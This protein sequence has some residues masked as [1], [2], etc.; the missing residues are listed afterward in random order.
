MKDLTILIT[1]CTAFSDMWSNTLSCFKKNWDDDS[2]IVLSSDG[3][4]IFDVKRVPEL[5]LYNGEMSKRIIDALK[6]IKT[7]Y[8]FITFDDY[9][10]I[11]KADVCTFKE[12]I[13]Y[14]DK[15]NVS[16]C[17]TAFNIK[18]GVKTH[19]GNLKLMELDLNKPYEVNFYPSI[20]NRNDLIDVLKYD[21]N[22]WVSEVRLTKR[23]KNN[24]K[25]A[26]L[27]LN[28]NVFPFLDVVRKGKY[29]RKAYKYLNKNDFY[30]SKR[31]VRT[32]REELYLSIRSFISFHSPKF[33]KKFLQN[34]YRKSGHI[35]FSDYDNLDA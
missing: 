19:S 4:G 6:D 35:I 22:I 2:G 3:E 14:M 9:Y 31:D 10:L 5:A 15:N 13:S 29:L 16:Y 25:K 32:R 17:G 21:E 11:E 12:L 20:W 33:L 27:I 24:G 7:K 34:K 28:K 1:S 8:V 26:I 18:S 23:L 30:I